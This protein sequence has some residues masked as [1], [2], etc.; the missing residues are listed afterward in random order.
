MSGILEKLFHT[1]IVRNDFNDPVLGPMPFNGD[2]GLWHA[3]LPSNSSRAISFFVAGESE[4][5]PKLLEHARDV[6]R[7]IHTFQSTIQAFLAS[8]APKFRQ[9]APTV[10]ALSTESLNLFWPSRPDD[11]MV[12][13]KGSSSDSRVWRCDYVA[14]QPRALGYDS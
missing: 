13:F 12:Y 1:S 11:G 7:K 8:E 9:D 5:D 4:P 3:S 2:L 10:L 14:R 6:A